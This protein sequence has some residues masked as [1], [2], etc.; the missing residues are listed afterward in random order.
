M[1]A[2]VH[3]IQ[4]MPGLRFFSKMKNCDVF[5]FLDDVQYVKREFQNRNRI[6]TKN[7]WQY[8]TL[9]V[10][11]KG[12]FFQKIYEVEINNTFNWK[13]EHLKSIK[14]NYAKARY[15]KD[16]FSSIEEIY[17]K[18]YSKM[19]DISMELIHFFRRAFN[20]NTDFIFSSD[21]D[22]KTS[23]T[24]RIVDICLKLKA[25]AYLSGVGGKDYLDET[26]FK[27]NGIKLLWQDFK[28]KPY[29]QVYEGFVE[30][31]SAIDLLLNCGNDSVYYL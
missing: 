26:I 10:I 30:N 25:D 14:I 3:Q 19:I 28:I 13:E 7:G 1:I 29:P 27:K 21:L 8:L 11:T 31:L 16:Y 6:R 23:S 17:A 20:I 4:F 12:R 24:Q 9:P 5:V 22:I 15:F 2:A 18:E